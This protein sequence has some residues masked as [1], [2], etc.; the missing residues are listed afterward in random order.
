MEVVVGCYL[1]LY[2]THRLELGWASCSC[3]CLQAKTSPTNIHDK[4][5]F[6]FLTC[7]YLRHSVLVG[8]EHA[9][10]VASLLLQVACKCGL[11]DMHLVH[12]H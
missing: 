10:C 11:V 6:Y 3:T 5:M 8:T 2:G 9:T 12:M 7:T 1:C 4:V